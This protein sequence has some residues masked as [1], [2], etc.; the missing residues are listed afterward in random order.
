MHTDVTWYIFDNLLSYQKKKKR[1][2]EAKFQYPKSGYAFGEWGAL[3]SSFLE[4]IT[5]HSPFHYLSLAGMH[6]FS[7]EVNGGGAWESQET[8]AVVEMPEN[9]TF[10][11]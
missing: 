10:F 5:G 3:D 4:L 7:E 6:T 11:T 2:N 8:C 9:S 1:M